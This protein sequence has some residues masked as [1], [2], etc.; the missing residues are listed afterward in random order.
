MD[1]K[2]GD[3]L[4]L[5]QLDEVD[6]I[7]KICD[8]LSSKAYNNSCLSEIFDSLSHEDTTLTDSTDD[9]YSVT[10]TEDVLLTSMDEMRSEEEALLPKVLWL[11]TV[12]G[13]MR[14][15]PYSVLDHLNNCVVIDEVGVEES[16]S[17]NGLLGKKEDSAVFSFEEDDDVFVESAKTFNSSNSNRKGKVTMLLQGKNI[18]IHAIICTYENLENPILQKNP[19]PKSTLIKKLQRKHCKI[20]LNVIENCHIVFP[21]HCTP[22]LRCALVKILPQHNT[23]E[24]FIIVWYCHDDFISQPSTED[25][26][27]LCFRNTEKRSTRKWIT[28]FYPIDILT[29][30]QSKSVIR[31][32]IYSWILRT[33]Y[34]HV[35][36]DYES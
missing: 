2:K 19:F 6:N 18:W 17:I 27:F 1:T 24:C 25:N 31:P 12:L 16:T 8:K 11:V 29:Q 20:K 33:L 15:W 32:T 7:T 34:W 26:F 23:K 14:E 10:G 3:M 13:P 22:F 21:C 30:E 28:S 5:E 36:S 9:D 35:S 4:F